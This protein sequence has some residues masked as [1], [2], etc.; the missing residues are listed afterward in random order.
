MEKATEMFEN[1]KR[2][3]KTTTDIPE[4]ETNKSKYLYPSLVIIP[5]FISIL[6]I[7]ASSAQLAIKIFA[8]IL[9]LIALFAFYCLQ[10]NINILQYFNKNKKEI[11]I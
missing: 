3:L 8:I 6:I 5:I 9:L 11:I 7:L 4:N 1:A 2:S 10:K